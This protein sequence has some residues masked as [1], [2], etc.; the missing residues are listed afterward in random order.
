MII[1]LADGRLGNQIFQYAFLKTIQK[2][3]EN[4]IVSGFEDLQEVFEINDIV[5]LN[6]N[7]RWGNTFLSR[8]CKP[9]L[10]F[11]SDK[12]IISSI[13]VNHEKILDKYTRESGAYTKQKGWFDFITFVKLGFFQSEKFFNKNIV[14]KLKVQEKYLLEANNFLSN[15]PRAKYTIFIHIRRGDY[16]D[17]T[18]YGKSALLP[19]SY[20]KEQIEWFIKN[21]E[22]PFF[23]FLSDEPEEIESEFEYIDN[24]IISKDN[25]FGTDLAIMTQ[26]K[27]AILSP[28][29]LSWWGS[30]LMEDKDIVFAPKYWL[31][32]KSSVEFHSNS[33]A[34]F[35][36]VVEIR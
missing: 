19:I 28:S 21:K 4:I 26:C 1:F 18:V 3:N 32:F 9:I 24:K 23:V 27:S 11:I 12:K 34:N 30:Y 6:K 10:Y 33:I 7:N 13:S 20:Y 31:G 16:K 14:K 35:C 17:Y 2:N 5:N 22:N 25:Y 15:V 8:I 36:K 29:S